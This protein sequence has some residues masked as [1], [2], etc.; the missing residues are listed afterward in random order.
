MDINDDNKD[1]SFYKAELESQKK[2]VK[3]AFKVS[4]ILGFICIFFV[5]LNLSILFTVAGGIAGSDR[6]INDLERQIKIL[7]ESIQKTNY[8]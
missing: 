3:N 8:K 1:L 2:I 5:V 6:K 7:Q 4:I